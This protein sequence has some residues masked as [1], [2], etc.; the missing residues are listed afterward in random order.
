[1]MNCTLYFV[2][3]NIFQMIVKMRLYWNTSVTHANETTSLLVM[4]IPYI[5]F[6]FILFTVIVS[7]NK[8]DLLLFSLIWINKMDF[9]LDKLCLIHP[10]GQHWGPNIGWTISS[11][12]LSEPKS[13]PDLLMENSV[14]NEEAD[15]T[16]ELFRDT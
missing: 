5:L 8:K 16:D 12:A 9:P 10:F 4:D 14:N 7:K 1:M 15:R 6:H 3:V 13:T 11:W 2:V